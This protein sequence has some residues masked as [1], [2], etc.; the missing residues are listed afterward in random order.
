MADTL[1]KLQCGTLVGPTLQSF[2]RNKTTVTYCT[3]A[4]NMCVRCIVLQLIRVKNGRKCNQAFKNQYIEA[5]EKNASASL[6]AI[7]ITLL[8]TT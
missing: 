5:K 3:Y 7:R 1:K 6:R 8:R 4:L 2:R